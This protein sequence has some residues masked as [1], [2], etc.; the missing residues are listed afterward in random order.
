MTRTVEIFAKVLFSVVWFPEAFFVKYWIFPISI[1]IEVTVDTVFGN[2][3]RFIVWELLCIS[4]YLGLEIHLALISSWDPSAFAAFCSWGC[5][6]KNYFFSTRFEPLIGKHLNRNKLTWCGLLKCSNRSL[7]QSLVLLISQLQLEDI[8]LKLTWEWS[9]FFSWNARKPSKMGS[10][11][12]RCMFAGK[13]ARRAAV[14]D[15]GV[16]VN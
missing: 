12:G 10:D 5:P 6:V 7:L 11:K 14:G 13:G 4:L 1:K 16:R 15:A 8:L 2:K 3:Q 9:G